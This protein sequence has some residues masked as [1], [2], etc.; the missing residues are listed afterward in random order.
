MK[1]ANTSILHESALKA[2]AQLEIEK[3][4]WR[5]TPESTERLDARIRMIKEGK[6]FRGEGQI[7]Y[8][9]R[10]C[11]EF[12]EAI[13]A[14]QLQHAGASI[15]NYEIEVERLKSHLETARTLLGKPDIEITVENYIAV[16][17]TLAFIS[18]A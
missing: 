7:N 16:D 13:Y 15:P 9:T 3:N 17:F 8:L 5:A 12:T 6:P 10:R 18:V 2:I 1:L 14:L 11:W 4:S